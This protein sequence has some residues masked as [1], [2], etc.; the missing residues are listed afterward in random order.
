MKKKIYAA[1]LCVLMCVVMCVPVLA[2]EK[3][4][5]HLGSAEAL[6][7]CYLQQNQDEYD[8]FPP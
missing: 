3:D 8:L 4:H 6:M 7:S 5:T 1:V 2:D